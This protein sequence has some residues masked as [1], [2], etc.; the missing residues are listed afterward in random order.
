MTSMTKT[1]RIWNGNKVVQVVAVSD[2]GSSTI[3]ATG[4]AGNSTQVDIELDPWAGLIVDNRAPH[5][6]PVSIREEDE[7]E[8]KDDGEQY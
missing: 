6:H 8:P 7:R 1:I 3:G 4:G 5:P 2:T